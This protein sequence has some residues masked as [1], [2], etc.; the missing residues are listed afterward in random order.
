MASTSLVQTH[1][2]HKLDPPHN[3]STSHADACLTSAKYSIVGSRLS[4]CECTAGRGS[5]DSQTAASKR[6]ASTARIVF[7]SNIAA[8]LGIP[9][10]G[11]PAGIATCRP[12]SLFGKRSALNSDQCVLPEQSSNSDCEFVAVRIRTPESNQ[13]AR[14]C[15][16]FFSDARRAND[17]STR[18]ILATSTAATARRCTVDDAK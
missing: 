12:N 6:I 11:R 3:P 16:R 14:W 18:S 7:L 13:L 1:L 2:G 15:V 9:V 4:A 17:S 5:L 8:C 10:S